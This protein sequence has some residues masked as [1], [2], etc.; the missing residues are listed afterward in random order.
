VI[1]TLFILGTAFALIYV[2]WMIHPGVGI[3]I[4]L[5]AYGAVDG[6]LSKKP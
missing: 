5:L 3:L 2:G 4:A 6:L 1:R